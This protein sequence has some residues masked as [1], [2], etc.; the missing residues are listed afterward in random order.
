MESEKKNENNMHQS[1]ILISKDL[2][3][4]AWAFLIDLTE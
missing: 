3:E 4:W 1:F 2:I